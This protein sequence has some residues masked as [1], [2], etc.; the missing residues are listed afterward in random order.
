MSKIKFEILFLKKKSSKQ[1]ITENGEDAWRHGV[2]VTM[3]SSD[4]ITG[5]RAMKIP[6]PGIA[7]SPHHNP[8]YY[9]DPKEE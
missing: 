8:E 6:A 1:V 3:N 9:Q 5:G 2:V 4:S 7:P